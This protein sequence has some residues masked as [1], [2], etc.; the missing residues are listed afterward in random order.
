MLIGRGD[1]PRGL[2]ADPVLG[3]F[4][5]TVRCLYEALRADRIGLDHS[6]VEGLGLHTTRRIQMR[7]R[8][9]YKFLNFVLGRSL[10]HLRRHLAADV[11]LLRGGRQPS[12]TLILILLPTVSIHVPHRLYRALIGPCHLVE[13]ETIVHGL[14]A[15]GHLGYLAAF[16]RVSSLVARG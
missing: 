5:K 3:C 4:H 6:L 10:V 7:G 9:R 15:V 11:A 16:R 1:V 2:R 12:R 8:L 13:Q 14:A